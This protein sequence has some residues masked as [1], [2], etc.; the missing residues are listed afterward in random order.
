MPDK[1]AALKRVAVQRFMKETARIAL[2]ER[3]I[4][5]GLELRPP[6]AM[7]PDA[8]DMW[9]LYQIVRKEKPK[10]ILEFGSGCSTQA[11]AHGLLKNQLTDDMTG[12]LYS[13]E[14]DPHY[15][16]VTRNHIPAYLKDLYTVIPSGVVTGDH[17]GTGVLRHT[18]IPDVVPDLMYLDSPAF[19]NKPVP[20]GTVGAY[21][22]NPPRLMDGSQEG[23]QWVLPGI[24]VAADILDMEDR[25]PVGCV[26]IV[27][28]RHTNRAY[29]VKHLKRKWELRINALLNNSKFTLIE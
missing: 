8:R 9:C 3:G 29:L 16:D 7:A 21:G 20:E 19:D 10:V 14:V 13:L 15:V 2:M 17:E 27:D 11:M 4:I 1:Y 28:G 24:Q 5:R 26:V 23:M 6:D 22:Y 12:H 18:N 25:L